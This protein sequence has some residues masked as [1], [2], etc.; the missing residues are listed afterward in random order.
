M[1]IA[2]LLLTYGNPMFLNKIK[3]LTNN[4]DL[5]IHP[6]YS[7]DI[8]DSLKKYIIKDLV[9]TNWGKFSLVT[10]VIN[11]LK[12]AVHK[13][14]DY[15]ILL[16]GDT[17]PLY[18][19]NEFIK[20][21]NNMV[22]S[23]ESIFDYNGKKNNF[24]KA[25]QWWALNDKDANVLVNTFN[26]YKNKFHK[27]NKIYGA[28]D[29]I[30]FLT[31]LNWENTNYNFINT[32]IMYTR[33]LKN[34]ISKHPLYF[35]KLTKNDMIDIAK[36]NGL[37]I[38]KCFEDFN[39]NKYEPKKKLYIIY[40]GSDTKQ[41]DILNINFNEYDIIILSSIELSDID[42]NI[43]NKCVYLFKII[44][45]FYEQVIVDICIT[46]KDI[47]KQWVEIIFTTETFNFKNIQLTNTHKNFKL[48]NYVLKTI[49]L[50]DDNANYS[51]KIQ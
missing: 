17:Y 26:K 28:Y 44:W 32:K 45:K 48:N 30:Y 23:G 34:V 31:V 37:F 29:E 5:Y 21:F 6:K 46:M 51:Y 36:N 22:L 43:I 27:L 10:A 41:N 2:F 13:K 8:D 20:L 49:I 38:R 33:W 11:M 16:S 4:Y 15:Y 19:S 25:S 47:I 14:Y 1:K 9:E 39:I 50:I 7:N 18:D 12:E 3:E 42:K 35:N 40:I 24:Y